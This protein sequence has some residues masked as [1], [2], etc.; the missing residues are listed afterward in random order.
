MVRETS[1]AS[2][3]DETVPRP[4]ERASV[5][6]AEVGAGQRVG[7]GHDTGREA[8]GGERQAGEFRGDG[9]GKNEVVRDEDVVRGR[10]A[11]ERGEDVVEAGRDGAMH[12]RMER[13]EAAPFHREDIG[14][15][16]HE[17]F[18]RR[19]A[20]RDEAQSGDFSFRCPVGMA[21]E[22]D[23]VPAR[24]Q[25][26]SQGEEGV[27]IAVRTPGGEKETHSFSCSGGL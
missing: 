19:F 2:G 17:V 8:D 21:D 6:M 20:S 24:E 15:L 23:L 14:V 16:G 3:P 7:R 13:D 25:P 4:A 22:R 26:A 10:S 27:Q 5:R 1:R 11:Q 18:A 12:E 9:R